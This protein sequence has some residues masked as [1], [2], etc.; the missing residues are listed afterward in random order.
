MRNLLHPLAGQPA[1]SDALIDVK[2]LQAAYGS[3]R[4]DLASEEQRVVF[5]TSGHRGSAL[6]ASFNEW[7]VLAITQ[8][9]CDCR[10]RLGIEGPL[11]LGADTH[12]LSEPAMASALARR[13]NVLGAFKVPDP[14]RVAGRR[15]LLV[16]D[17]F[18]TGATVES[19]ARALKRAGA[20]RV[21]VLVL[22]R[23]VKAS[24][25]RI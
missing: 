18:T 1:P 8:A 11:F 7:H 19:C 2:A 10:K 16:D 21:H 17:V 9:I 22:A 25:V 6:D 14:A 5:G 20:A 15:V 4:P 3:R 13:R 12:A 23:V 24:D